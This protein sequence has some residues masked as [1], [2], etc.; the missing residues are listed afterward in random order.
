MPE[1]R[2]HLQWRRQL[3]LLSRTG[4]GLPAMA[5]A[6]CA[7][8]RQIV[9][10]QTCVLMWVDSAGMPVGVHHEHPN[11]ATQALFMNEYERL[12]SGDREINVSWAARQRGQACGRLL[13][14]PP[15]YFR[16]NTYNLLIRGDHY[17]HMLDLRIDVDGMARAVVALC[18]PPGKAFDQWRGKPRGSAH[19]ITHNSP[20]AFQ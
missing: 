6:L 10:A 9:G 16:S 4:V 8:V 3:D 15:A 7:L 18:R 5:P 20:H 1:V 13:N 17:R 19:P 11:E 14:P 2:Q 12:F